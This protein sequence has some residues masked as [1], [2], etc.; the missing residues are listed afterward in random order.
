MNDTDRLQ[1]LLRAALPPADGEPVADLWP[2]VLARVDSPPRW[3]WIDAGFAAIA[4]ATLLLYPEGLYL[5]A[6]HF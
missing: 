1:Q 6:F 2:R 3:S 4:A 5:L